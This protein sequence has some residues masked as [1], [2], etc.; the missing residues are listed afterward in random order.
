MKY[1]D[2]SISETDAARGAHKKYLGGGEAAWDSRGGFQLALLKHFGLEPRDRLVDYGCGPIRAGRFFVDFLEAGNYHGYDFNPSFV[3]IARA[4]IEAT[5]ALLAKRPR[6]T[7]ETRFLHLHAGCDVL[8]LFS[9]LNHCSPDQRRA[10]LDFVRRQDP[11]LRV[12]MSHGRW[13]RRL[14]PA[15]TEGIRARRVLQ[16][17][18]PDNLEVTRWGWSP[19]D[20]KRVFPIWLL[21]AEA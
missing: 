4:E 2:V 17:D 19:D 9:V 15:A 14:D 20:A 10:L 16:S 6:V 21:S 12:I 7:H 1:Q 18:L 5:P 13:F 8:L 11:A 3:A